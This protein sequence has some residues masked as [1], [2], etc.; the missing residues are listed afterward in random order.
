MTKLVPNEAMI[1]AC[2]DEIKSI[3]I[4]LTKEVSLLRDTQQDVF[5]RYTA[6]NFMSAIIH[7][8]DSTNEM[9]GL[10]FNS[11]HL[12]NHPLLQT[13]EAK[14]EGWDNLDLKN[15]VFF[16]EDFD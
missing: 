8:F 1:N 15:H 14:K 6:F 9:I 5:L 11:G 4:V 12:M 7:S 16:K 2:A 13:E 3:I 10:V